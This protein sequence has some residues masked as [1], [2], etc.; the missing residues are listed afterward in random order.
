MERGP[1]KRRFEEPA[2]DFEF[3]F[4]QQAEDFGDSEDIY[5]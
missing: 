3:E 2:E 4:I 1:G 5:H